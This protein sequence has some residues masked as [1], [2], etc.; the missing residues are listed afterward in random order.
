MLSMTCRK[1]ISENLLK[2]VRGGYLVA[3]DSLP[4]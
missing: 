2:E 4:D 1:I 3:H